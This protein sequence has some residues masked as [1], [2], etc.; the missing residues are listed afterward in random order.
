MVINLKYKWFVDYVYNGEIKRLVGEHTIKIK[1]NTPIEFYS[2]EI[3]K[4]YL[5]YKKK[6]G[7][8]YILKKDMYSIS[9]IKKVNHLYLSE[10]KK[11]SNDK[12]L[13][14]EIMKLL[15]LIKKDKRLREKIDLIEEIENRKGKGEIEF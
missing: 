8:Y 12:K 2:E 11:D 5:K 14:N 9:G 3:E 13:V 4:F 15:P 7:A 6:V 1:L 10:L